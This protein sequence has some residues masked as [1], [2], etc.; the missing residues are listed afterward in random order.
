V[1]YYIAEVRNLASFKKTQTSMEGK[2]RQ[3]YCS[4]FTILI[5]EGKQ[6]PVFEAQSVAAED[7]TKVR[8]SRR[9]DRSLLML[10]SAPLD[11]GKPVR[12]KTLEQVDF[13]TDPAW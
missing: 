13:R 1:L 3:N 2:T 5:S 4:L 10:I 11:T 9:P 8:E 7:L 6:I 12:A